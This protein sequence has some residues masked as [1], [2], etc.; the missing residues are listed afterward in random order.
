MTTAQPVLLDCTR[1]IARYWSGA[2]PTGID[3]VADAYADDQD[4]AERMRQELVKIIPAAAHNRRYVMR[5]TGDDNEGKAQLSYFI[6]NDE[7]YPVIATTSPAARKACTTRS[8]CSGRTR[9]STCVTASR[10]RSASQ[11]ARSIQR[12]RVQ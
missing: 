2:M 4:H 7:P 5:I 12:Q 8:L 6:D 3:R 11:A 10:A 1:M 9:H